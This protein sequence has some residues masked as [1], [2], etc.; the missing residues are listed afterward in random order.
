MTLAHHATILRYHQFKY[1]LFQGGDPLSIHG[2]LAPHTHLNPAH[3]LLL[4]RSSIKAT[5]SQVN[6]FLLAYTK[7]YLTE[8]Q[9]TS[10]RKHIIKASAQFEAI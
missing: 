4:M 1:Y 10:I 7:G 9:V 2:L 3:T 6:T 5:E 8:Q